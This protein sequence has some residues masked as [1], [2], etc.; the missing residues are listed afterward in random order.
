MRP[1]DDE[2]QAGA[3]PAIAAAAP[4]LKPDPDAS[5]NGNGGSI[6]M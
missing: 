1:G 3:E 6:V 5:W 2:Q 4:T